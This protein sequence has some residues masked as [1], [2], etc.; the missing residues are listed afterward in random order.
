[1]TQLIFE[2]EVLTAP[3][4]THGRY[5]GR[6]RLVSAGLSNVWRYGD[7]IL[8]ADSGRL[9]LRGPNGTGKTTA[10]EAL[11]PYLLDLD[12][13]KLRA[14][15]SRT[16]TLTSL[17][18]EG[19]H[20]R[21]RIGYAWLTFA[22]PADEGRVSYGARLV[23]SNGSTPNVK[24]EPFRVPGEPVT[25]LP[26]TGP[27]RSPI[28][29][30]EAFKE[31]VEAAGGI[32][33]IDEAEYVAALAG[34]V[35]GTSRESLVLLADRIRRVRN[36]SL[37]A[38]TSPERAAEAVREALPSVAPEVI[39]QTG[40]ALAATDET[41][42]AFER[43]AGA[44]EQLGEFATIW[45]QHAVEVCGR[46]TEQAEVARTDLTQARREAKRQATLHE[47]AKEVAAQALADEEAADAR[48]ES[49]HAEIDAIKKSPEYQTVERL[50]DLREATRAKAD[51]ATASTQ[52]LGTTARMLKTTADQSW[53]EAERITDEL[54]TTARQAAA[55]DAD[56]GAA[57][58]AVLTRPHATLKVGDAS[59]DP[60][61]TL[62]LTGDPDELGRVG[63][64]WS[65]RAAS[66]ET[67]AAGAELMLTEHRKVAAATTEAARAADRADQ[68]EASAD[69][70]GQER[71]QK[72]AAANRAA[73]DAAAAI[74]TWA[75]ENP[76][77][78][79]E[80]DLDPLSAEVIEAHRADGPAALLEVATDWSAA[81]STRAEGIA[82][83]LEALARDRRRQADTLGDEAAQHRSRAG[84]LRAGKVIQPSRP[85]W[86]GEADERA[87]AH[88]LQWRDEAGSE[89]R[90]LVESALLAAGLLGATLED[91]ALT[92]ASWRITAQAPP[93]ERNL[94][95]L[96]EADPEHPGSATAFA[97]LKQIALTDTVAAAPAEVGTVIA[98]D[99]SFRL[100]AIAGRAPGSDDPA[101]LPV[102]RY[103]GAAQRR[104]AALA[105]ADR[106][107]ALAAGL[108]RQ[109]R[110][111]LDEAAE[112]RESATSARTR[113]RGFPALVDL[114][115]SEHA[116]SAAAAAAVGLQRTA[117]KLRRT[118]DASRRHAQELLAGWSSAVVAMGLPADVEQLRDAR[119]AAGATARS[120]RDCASRLAS[121]H[122][123]V[124]GLRRRIGDAA[125]E[126]RRLDPVHAAAVTAHRD[127]ERARLSYVR[128]EAAHGRD[129]AELTSRLD[130]VQAAATTGKKMLQEAQQKYLKAAK[131]ETAAERDAEHAR[132]SAA[133]RE[134]AA[135]AAL[136]RLASLVNIP[137]VAECLLAG[138]PPEASEALIDQVRR[139]LAGRTTSG[140]RKLTES[141]D[142][143]R[144]QLS[145]LWAIDRA[146]LHPELDTYRC[147]Y[148]GA[149]LTPVAAAA[150]ARDT[151]ERAKKQLDDA[152][153]AALRDF[154]VGRLPT[155]IGR[156]WV[157][158]RDWVAAVNSKMANASASSGVGVRVRVE[159]RD[160]LT[161]PQRTVHRL[162]CRKSA[163]SR[164]V[165]EDEELSTA[166]KSLLA[167][168]D[169][170][171]V[172]DRVRQ[173]VDLRRWLRVDYFIHRPGEEP[174]RWTGRTGLS[175]GERRLVILAP[176]LAA[177]AALHDSFPAT[178]LRL[179]ALDE[180]PAEVD[181]RGR[182]GLARYLAELDLDVICT[183]YL[184][185]GAPG[186]WDGVDAYD[187]EAYGDVVVAF[188]ILVRGLESLP[189]D[190]GLLP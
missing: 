90:A 102:S 128:L 87:F 164:S 68:A 96:L 103:I 30:A 82:A 111:L 184:W 140:R 133:D 25:D 40:E 79:A 54:H 137:D 138:E 106:L 179:A 108:E 19:H 2:D 72:T 11:W 167:T 160:D 166:L 49:A 145:G 14:G 135:Q 113:A 67:R 13:Q 60:G 161:P 107:D 58:F 9:L 61:P 70:A 98:L 180:V 172:T 124:L 181:E 155:A 12:R 153:E 34:Q 141:Y 147:S 125:D 36:P 3:S 118:A 85:Q 47:R 62:E 152:E 163:S 33:F 4:G 165:T 56:A 97:V 64:Q 151:A 65:R 95:E 15:Q 73:T 139:H 158:L 189:G 169:G 131:D 109:R 66:H 132:Q 42:A 71:D 183:S 182:E 100:G 37:L 136:E 149:V 50:A 122:N 94:T 176:M 86:A 48:L 112:L 81:A 110:H 52:T 129:A 105:E 127:A 177:I 6:W 31:A 41:R 178:S 174:T 17:M 45:A 35:F 28:T 43:D 116:R 93:V 188:R 75:A 154:I 77:L 99:G 76:D 121:L 80:P 53:S 39:E 134:P 84:E 115:T 142:E 83:G 51:T 170:E 63:E 117:E 26:L 156:A 18:R 44:A 123:Q 5:G 150:L 74:A 130:H 32:V 114:R 88:A 78:T 148:D 104:A 23:F 91:D 101:E 22:G 185:D 186:A 120:L 1:M 159:V 38:E 157:E 144:A 171:T 24:V 46:F 59:F 69:A 27:G 190:E 7:L 175:G 55:A 20:D 187:L 29:T 143:T 119:R 16:T 168:A 57:T 92:A 8:P 10:L 126:R 21:K 162:A 146:D 173:A 89:Q